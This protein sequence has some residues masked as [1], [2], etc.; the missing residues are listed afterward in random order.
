MPSQV[1]KENPLTTKNPSPEFRE[2]ILILPVF[3]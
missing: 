1:K 3:Y 2:G